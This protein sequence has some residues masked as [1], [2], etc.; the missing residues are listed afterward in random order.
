MFFSRCDFL[1]SRNDWISYGSG[2][3]RCCNMA[4]F[5]LKNDEIFKYNITEWKHRYVMFRCKS[6]RSTR[7]QYIFYIQREKLFSFWWHKLNVTFHIR[8]SLHAHIHVTCNKYVSPTGNWFWRRQAGS[9][10][11]NREIS[12]ETSLTIFHL[13]AVWDDVWQNVP[14]RLIVRHIGTTTF[15]II[16]SRIK[17]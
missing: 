7:K 15:Y 5:F 12:E 9:K 4:L 10:W 17:N 13:E 14:M 8:F 1:D 6:R 2:L 16:L 11:V 3:R